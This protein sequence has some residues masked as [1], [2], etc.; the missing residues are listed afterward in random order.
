MERKFSF[1]SAYYNDSLMK[2]NSIRFVK[3]QSTETVFY[4]FNPTYIY[5]GNLQDPLGN[6]KKTCLEPRISTIEYLSALVEYMVVYNIHYHDLQATS[7]V[8]FSIRTAPS[9]GCKFCTSFHSAQRW[10]YHKKPQVWDPMSDNNVSNSWKEIPTNTMSQ[11]YFSVIF[12]VEFASNT[13]N[14]DLAFVDFYSCTY[15]SI[16]FVN[17][18]GKFSI[19]FQRKIQQL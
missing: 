18:S 12:T 19:M 8:R 5:K 1:L 3:N 4:G 14:N 16:S 11:I 13:K 9:E 6:V 15:I 10:S 17:K 2:I 7:L